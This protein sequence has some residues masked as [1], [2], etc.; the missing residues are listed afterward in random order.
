MFYVRGHQKQPHINLERGHSWW[1]GAS[2]CLVVHALA[3]GV[4]R[5][6]HRQQYGRCIPSH[7]A[8]GTGHGL[9]GV[10]CGYSNGKGACKKIGV[11]TKVTSPVPTH[12][13]ALDL[14]G[15]EHPTGGCNKYEYIGCIN[16]PV[17]LDP[18]VA[19]Q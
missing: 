15:L 2:L 13:K 11:N 17:F 16:P 3:P 8:R 12:Q 9:H 5:L 19:I 4:E 1:S 7:L 6:I 14:R 18:L 10:G